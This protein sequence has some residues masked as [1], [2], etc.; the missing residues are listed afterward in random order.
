MDRKHFDK[1]VQAMGEEMESLEFRF[2]RIKDD[3]LQVDNVI[4]KFFPDNQ[5]LPTPIK[6]LFDLS[7]KLFDSIEPFEESMRQFQH[8]LQLILNSYHS[9]VEEEKGKYELEDVERIDN[10][11][12]ESWK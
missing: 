3:H 2:E 8:D 5:V 1:K 10:N 11:Y 12:L 6:Q 7:T 4:E 9:D